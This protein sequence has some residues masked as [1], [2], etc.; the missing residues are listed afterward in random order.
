MH[1]HQ[2]WPSNSDGDMF[3]I[4]AE[5][6]FD[7]SKEQE[8]EFTIDFKS[9]PLNQEQ[10]AAIRERLP[11]AS[12]V[13][14]D[15]TMLEGGENSGYLS[16]IIKR[17]ITYDFI[18]SEQKRLTDIVADLGGYCDSWSVNSPCGG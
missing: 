3:R 2:T 9:W 6:N 14:I 18:I 4:L 5:R 1:K 11:D 12:T 17:E 15:E 7:F 13:S 16:F 8:I 10:S